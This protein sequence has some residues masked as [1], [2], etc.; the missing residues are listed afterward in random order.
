MKDP[1][2]HSDDELRQTTMKLTSRSRAL[3]AEEA[4][5]LFRIRVEQ[6]RRVNAEADARRDALLASVQ[7]P[8]PLSLLNGRDAAHVRAG[9]VALS[10]QYVEGSRAS[11]EIDALHDKVPTVSEHKL[12]N[13]P[14]AWK[15]R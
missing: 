14:G 1:T 12:T 3:R 13:L 9:L 4:D 6:L 8:H 2:A 5:L 11:A 15:K 7:P 10:T